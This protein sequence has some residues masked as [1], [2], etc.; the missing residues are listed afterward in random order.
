MDYIPD[1]DMSAV[2][3]ASLTVVQVAINGGVWVSAADV[4]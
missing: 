3:N 4:T 2:A 1:E